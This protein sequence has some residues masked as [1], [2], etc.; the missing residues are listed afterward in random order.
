M[1]QHPCDKDDHGQGRKERVSHG[2]GRKSATTDADC[3]QTLLPSQDRGCRAGAARRL[4]SLSVRVRDCG[5]SGAHAQK[6]A[7]SG[8]ATRIDKAVA[9]RRIDSVFGG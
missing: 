6:H 4:S 3:T 7:C 9:V 2:G 1:R 5:V 8:T